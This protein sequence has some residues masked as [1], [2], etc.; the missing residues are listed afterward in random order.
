MGLRTNWL[1][2]GRAPIIDALLLQALYRARRRRPRS[3]GS[4]GYGPA[5]AVRT[6]AASPA[7]RNMPPWRRD[8]E[9]HCGIVRTT[10]LPSADKPD[11]AVGIA[12]SSL[13]LRVV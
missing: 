5:Q 2:R 10:R 3:S 8:D 6:A 7:M 11:A 9:R 4:R 1:C 13:L 12:Q